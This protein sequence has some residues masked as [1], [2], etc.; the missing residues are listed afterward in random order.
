MYLS[1]LDIDEQMIGI[2]LLMYNIG[3]LLLMYNIGMLLLMYNATSN[4]V[5]DPQFRYD[6]YKLTFCDVL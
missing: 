5:V 2:L 1:V 6:G 4:G 3:M